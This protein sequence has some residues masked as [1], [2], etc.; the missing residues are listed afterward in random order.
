MAQPKEVALDVPATT[1][2][3]II[4][5]TVRPPNG[6][7]LLYSAPGYDKPIR[8]PGPSSTRV[9]PLHSR[10]VRIEPVDGAKTYRLKILGRIDALDGSHIQRPPR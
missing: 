5:V 8:F 10:T 7:I 9:V 2:V 4:Q 1:A 6:A 3:A